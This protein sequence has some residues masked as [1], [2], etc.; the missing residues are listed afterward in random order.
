MCALHRNTVWRERERERER[1]I[2]RES[3]RARKRTCVSLCRHAP[4]QWEILGQ[5]YPGLSTYWLLALRIND[6]WQLG[7]FEVAFRIR[8]S[9][10]A[11]VTSKAFG[12]SYA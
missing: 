2:E 5:S 3:A 9:A 4:A 7:L 10:L 1:E 12:V 11:L 8:L 6:P